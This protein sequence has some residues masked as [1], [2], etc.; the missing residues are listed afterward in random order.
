MFM[1]KVRYRDRLPNPFL[2]VCLI[3]AAAACSAESSGANN[4]V[5]SFGSHDVSGD[6]TVAGSGRDGDNGNAGFSASLPTG[7]G[8]AGS[9]SSLPTGNGNG[10]GAGSG[11]GIAGS[12]VGGSGPVGE[13][14]C[15][16]ATIEPVIGFVPGNLMI[17]FDRS[18]SMNDI[19]ES[20]TRLN[21]AYYA[22]IN[23]L[24]PFVCASDDP[25]CEEQLFV[26]AILFPSAPGGG[27]MCYTEDINS[28]QQINWMGAT[29]FAAAWQTYWHASPD[30]D[31]FVLVLSTPIT[32][33]F[34]HAADGI[35]AANLPGKTAVLFI[36]DGLGTCDQG[37]PA[38]VQAAAWLSE[39]ITTHVVSVAS[40]G[41]LIPGDGQ[42]FNDSVAAAGGTG[43]SL[44]PADVASLNTALAEII[45]SAAAAPSCE[46]SLE[47]GKL[48]DL[49]SACERGT[50]T[51]NGALIACDQ[52]D[53]IDGF[54]VKSADQIE[55]VGS[56][57]DKLQAEGQLSAAFPCDVIVLE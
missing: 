15:G 21:A 22:I 46:V 17:I 38:D 28:S 41:L 55:L 56:A 27:D 47:G 48:N 40:L 14:N 18:L 3:L 30:P 4:S 49:V 10:T 50:V 31:P 35:A 39:G 24:Q 2:F 29:Q 42:A 1:K 20:T 11:A 7:E 5:N 8:N 54:W 23:G 19:F 26:A 52:Q 34:H 53:K 32:T 25:D 36:T 57:C 37:T 13:E 45:Q 9:S 6:N 16:E 12:G 43:Q 51:V 33:A 44:N